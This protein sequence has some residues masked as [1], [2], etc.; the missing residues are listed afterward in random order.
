[1]TTQTSPRIEF[2]EARRAKNAFNISIITAV[3]FVL[4]VVMTIVVNRSAI[5]DLIS[6]VSVLMGAVVAGY[7]AYLSRRGK[8]DLGILLLI[9]TLILI[10]ISRVFVQ[11]GLAIPTGIVHIILV[12]SIAIYTLPT[13][14]IGRAITAAFINAVITILIDQSTVD[15]PP[16]PQPEFAIGISLV[17]GLIYLIILAMQF[18]KLPLRAKLIIGFIF[19]TVVPLVILGVV[20]NNA[21]RSILVDQIKAN[22]LETSQAINADFQVFVNAQRSAAGQLARMPEVV[23]YMSLPQQKRAGSEQEHLVYDNFA[24]IAKEDMIFI[25]SYALVDLNGVNVLDT[26]LSNRGTS[27]ATEEFFTSVIS[28]QKTYVSGLILTAA[29]GDRDIYFA[30]PVFSESDNLIGVLLIRYNASIIQSL[31]DQYNREHQAPAAATEYSYL[32]DDV[33]FF[34]I[35]HSVRADLLYKSY[36]EET[37]PRASALIERGA[38][39]PESLDSALLGQPE[40]ISHLSSVESEPVAFRAPS[41][42]NDGE[43]AEV[44]AV[45]V[46]N[47]TWIIVTGQ[48]VSTISTLTQSQTED[49]VR[50]SI[51]ITVFATLL[52]LLVSSLFT[53]PLLQLTRVAENISAGD[54]TQ[55]A[56][57]R[58]RDEIGVLANAFNNMS[59]QIQELVAGL[60]RRVQERT[61]ELAHTTELSEKR[62]Q[63]LQTISEVARYVST[64]KDLQTLL[65]L[66][67]RVVSERFGFYH[68]GIFLLDETGRYAVL[69]AANS[70]G[71]Q[72]MLARQ[73]RLEVGQTGIVGNVTSTGTPRVALDTGADAVYFNNPNLPDTR[74]EMAL[75]LTARGV[76]IGALDVQSTAQ[77]A[78]TEADVAILSLLADQVA[79]AIDNARLIDEAQN[80]LA[81]SQAIFSE[82]IAESWQKKT[83]AGILGYHQTLSGGRVITDLASAEPKEPANGHKTLEIPIRVRDQV[84]GKLDIKPVSNDTEWSEDDLSVVQAIAE[85]LGLAL[86][87]ARLF[88]ETSTRASRERLVTEITTRIR[89]TN[90]PQEMIKT[91]VEELQRALGASRVEIVPQKISPSPDQ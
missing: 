49:T 75:P 22:I 70:S 67:T 24:E 59:S 45:R 23:A 44:A 14:W 33:N 1:M 16:S 39:K 42:E 11:K 32:V 41:R 80:A 28:A 73:H 63:Q 72:E 81:E 7:S 90:N 89:G 6:L 85:R 20:A 47:T 12:S 40:L 37:D 77:N 57:I 71:G 56:N 46:P 74:S 78:F 52:A 83:S 19:L 8:S 35:G 17:L 65:P 10:V 43:P 55:R 2:D 68:V 69:R 88:E 66:I 48:P 62:A 25:K 38:I 64:E 9:S 27:Y 26:I 15:V 61:S 13:K 87:N 36:L 31:F 60:E 4:I 21:T 58:S 50:T 5:T 30:T 82:Y 29:T 54:F 3:M 86:D 34:V 91:A 53:N 79:I 18:P 84:I 51:I 76:I